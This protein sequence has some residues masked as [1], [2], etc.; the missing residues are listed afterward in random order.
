M[1]SSWSVECD[2]SIRDTGHNLP[3]HL[4]H[5]YTH[6]HAYTQI[7]LANETNRSPSET[8]SSPSP[9]LPQPPP[10]CRTR[11]RPPSSYA[12]KAHSTR[13]K[14]RKRCHAN[15]LRLGD[16]KVKVEGGYTVADNP[17]CVAFTDHCHRH[18]VCRLHIA[19]NAG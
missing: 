9:S 2:R 6:T 11:R 5:T 4:S 19:F 3:S 8:L 7:S 10:S 1:I 16:T 15:S 17:L 12:G 14:T 13:H 18:T